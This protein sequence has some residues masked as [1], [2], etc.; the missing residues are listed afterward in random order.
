MRSSRPTGAEAKEKRL[1]SRGVPDDKVEEKACATARRIAE[2][3]PLVARWHKKFVNRL[4][5]SKPLTA[6]EYD[7][8]FACFGTEDYRTGRDSSL[9]KK[10]PDFKSR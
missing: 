8:S 10:K 4:M 9:A 6:E 2:G 7:E 3:A 5:D 1:V